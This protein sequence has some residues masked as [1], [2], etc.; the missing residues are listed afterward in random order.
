MI[1]ELLLADMTLVSKAICT[2]CVANAFDMN[3][4]TLGSLLDGCFCER[5]RIPETS[6]V[7]PT[8]RRPTYMLL[9]APD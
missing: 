7:V 2:T 9:A 3:V 6:A 5:H 4:S 8:G 1:T